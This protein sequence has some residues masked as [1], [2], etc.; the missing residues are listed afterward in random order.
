MQDSD[1]ILTRLINILK[2][3]ANNEHPN[4]KA[5]AH[6]FNVTKRTIQR[7]LYERLPYFPI[8]K[9]AQGELQFINGFSLEQSLLDDEEMMFT[10]LTLSQITDDNPHF[11]EK[12]E[13][14]LKKLIKPQRVVLSPIQKE[15]KTKTIQPNVVT[16]IEEAILNNHVLLI[17]F[18]EHSKEMKPYKIQENSSSWILLAHD[19]SDEKIKSIKLNTIENVHTLKQKFKTK[20]SLDETLSNVHSSFFNAPQTKVFEV[21]VDKKIA[22]YFQ[23]NRVL[24]SQ[25]IIKRHDD[26]ALSLKFQVENDNQIE[27]IIKEWLPYLTITKPAVYNQSLIKKMQQ[28][29][30]TCSSTSEQ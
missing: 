10:Y 7:D 12:I 17:D 6:E 8:E 19:C 24:P 14:I 30:Q 18:K 3:L 4:V 27:S 1:K 21:F 23:N 11:K 28:Y 2:K 22:Y 29:I 25:K 5:L 9:N 20:K 15:I 16:Q 26:G 13:T